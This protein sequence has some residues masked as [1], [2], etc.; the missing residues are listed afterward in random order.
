M[1][2]DG[3]T[4]L[5]IEWIAAALGVINISLLIF[6]SVWNYPFG[7]AMV[8]L[9]AWVFFTAKLYSDALLSYEGLAGEYAHQVVDHAVEYV[10]GNVHTTEWR[11][12][13]A[14]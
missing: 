1:V 12:F 5:I 8:A 6:R 9:Y 13:G 3:E 4:L 14:C 11:T 7:I 2:L 10:N